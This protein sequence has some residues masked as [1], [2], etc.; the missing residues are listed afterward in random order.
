MNPIVKLMWKVTGRTELKIDADKCVGC[1]KCA[2]TCHHNAVEKTA[3]RRYA[4]QV[5]RC[6]RCYHCKE[7]CPKQAIV[8]K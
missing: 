5:D 1:G 4:I 7:N 2:K 6:V 8:S 3:E